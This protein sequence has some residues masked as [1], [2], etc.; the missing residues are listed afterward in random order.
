MNLEALK[1]TIKQLFLANKQFVYK[2]Y[3]NKKDQILIDAKLISKLQRV[4]GVETTDTNLQKEV[5]K[6]TLRSIFQLKEE[7]LLIFKNGHAFIKL[8]TKLD[9]C[10]PQGRKNT[11]EV[12]YNGFDEKELITFY[13]EFFDDEDIS[14]LTEKVTEKFINKFI[15]QKS[16]SN[17]EYEK[18]VFA[19]IKD[20]FYE[21]LQKRFENR[22]EFLLGFSG[23]LFRINFEQ[24]FIQIAEKMLEKAAKG[25]HATKNFLEYYSQE[26]IIQNGQ[27][28]RVPQIESKSGHRWKIV[29]II[30]IARIYFS[31]Y[32]NITE[33]KNKIE[34]LKK[35]KQI[36]FGINT[37]G[38]TPLQ[39][40]KKIK[41]KIR[42]LSSELKEQLYVIESIHSK[43]TTKKLS[44][45]E[46]EELKKRLLFEKNEAEK[47]KNERERYKKMLIPDEKLLKYQKLQ[48]ELDLLQRELNNKRKL[49]EQ[50]SPSFQEIKTALLHA[51]TQKKKKI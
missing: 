22:D 48:R 18:K 46:S 29:S 14:K 15:I 39:K 32:A 1:D 23:Y 36:K 12:R 47:I 50:N 30:P 17:D 6:Q 11:N 45:Q 40:Q 2:E 35:E 49:L 41:E 4:I 37:G 3:N 33:L 10:I 42:S 20:L 8:I 51:L 31:T 27:K 28:Y 43:I 5:L 25:N 26:I 7:D 19:Y 13:N 21:F 9:R 38:M 44:A 16:I 24:V 34:T